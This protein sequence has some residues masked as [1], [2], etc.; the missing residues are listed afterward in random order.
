[1]MD[2]E[3]Q[4]FEGL[5]QDLTTRRKNI[6]VFRSN[7]TVTIQGIVGSF[8]EFGATKTKTATETETETETAI[9]I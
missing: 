3:K 6:E 1:M 4:I 5:R 7:G 9:S 2:L 8:Y